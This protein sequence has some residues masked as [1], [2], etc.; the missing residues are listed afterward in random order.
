MNE[1]KIEKILKRHD[2]E[3]QRYMGAL[4]EDFQSKLSGVAEGVVG[5]SEKFDRLEIKVDHLET[6]FDRLEIK[7]DRIEVTQNAHTE[8]IGILAEDVSEMK[9]E[10]KN[11]VSRTEFIELEQTVLAMS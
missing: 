1:E 3:M 10:S 8:M 7:V 5:L 9:T 11:K 6:R 4:S 2:E